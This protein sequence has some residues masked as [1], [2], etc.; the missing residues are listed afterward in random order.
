MM[1]GF[2]HYTPHDVMDD[3]ERLALRA[4]SDQQ[5]T[6]N[7][8]RL[9]HA[10]DLVGKIQPARWLIKN[11]LE[12]DALA[13][14]IAEPG[15]GKTFV[16]LDWAARIATGTEWFGRRVTQGPVVYVA[17][18]GHSGI[19]R[20]LHGWS[21]AHG[22]SLDAAPLYVSNRAAA[23]N[24]SEG[25][26][27]VSDALESLGNV[28]PRLLI[29]DTLARNFAGNE[30]SSEEMGAFVAALDAL[31]RPLGASVLVVH[32]SGL[33]GAERGRGSTAL[34]GAVDRE[35][36]AAKT[37]GVIVLRCHKAKDT[38]IPPPI[39][40]Q[41]ESVSLGLV[42]ED[43]DELTTA[44]LREAEVPKS[45]AKGLGANQARAMTALR[46]LYAKARTN[47]NRQGRGPDKALVS[48]AQW[49][50]EAD[51][52]RKRFAEVRRALEDRGAV[53]VEDGLH[54]RL[55]EGDEA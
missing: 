15:S 13:T 43:G 19:S 12:D 45:A 25:Y 39:G 51:L 24:A 23:L 30:N 55:P 5:A 37:D 20:R 18:E 42:D 33:G 2:P 34:R 8:F 27:A 38:E 50:E 1:P 16:A 10:S 17:G 3:D 6:G 31:R 48:L 29:V 49:K 47:L 32:H 53:I 9:I 46:K 26:M 54:V 28:S 14:L 52:D 4:L 40:L 21:L 22:V 7:V 44:A 41:L 11:V 36:I 35:W